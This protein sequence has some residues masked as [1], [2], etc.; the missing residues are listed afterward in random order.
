MI[1]YLVAAACLYA[2]YF[3]FFK[4]KSVI[5]DKKRKK[6]ESE[7]AVEC[8]SCSTYVGVSDALMVDGKYYCSKECVDR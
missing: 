1:K 6:D 3:I 4:K 5:E 2:I 8:S 7:E